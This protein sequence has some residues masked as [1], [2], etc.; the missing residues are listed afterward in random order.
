MA[1]V[2]IM[3][4]YNLNA[5]AAKHMM[6]SLSE[7]RIKECIEEYWSYAKRRFNER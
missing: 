2:A 5:A 6:E 4:V 1:L 3:H 7:E